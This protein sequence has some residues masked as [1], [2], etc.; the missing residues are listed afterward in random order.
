MLSLDQGNIN[1]EQEIWKDKY[2]EKH[3]QITV[4]EHPRSSP[5]SPVQQGV[6]EGTLEGTS[7]YL[8]SAVQ[9][10]PSKQLQAI[11]C[12]WPQGA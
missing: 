1:R 8:L 11:L 12:P 6:G 10:P 7:E 3:K 9:T 4:I 2:T 5:T